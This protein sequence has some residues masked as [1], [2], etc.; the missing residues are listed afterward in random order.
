VRRGQSIAVQRLLNQPEYIH[1]VINHF[2]L[3]GLLVA[4]MA[5]S[6]ALIARSRPTILL[7]LG[8]VLLFSLSVWPVY[9]FGEEGYDRVL[10]M[11]DEPG[12]AFLRYHEHLAERWVFLFYVT[13][14]LAALGLVMGWRF[15]RT[16]VPFSMAAL[17]FGLASLAA[18]IVIARAGGEVRHREF[19]SAPPPE[20]PIEQER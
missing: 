17:V 5:L 4:L 16:Q 12:Q 7:G 10:S 3:V 8:L 2:P 9:H 11:A 6:V 14:G 20:M 19:R 13:G 15:P 1:T 18:G